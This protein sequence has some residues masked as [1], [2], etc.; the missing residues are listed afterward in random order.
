MNLAQRRA[1][2][3]LWLLLTPL[4]LLGVVLLGGFSR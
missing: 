2:R 1:H 4:L 3:I